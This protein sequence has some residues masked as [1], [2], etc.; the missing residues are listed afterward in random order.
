MVVR[1]HKYY[2]RTYIEHFAT[3]IKKIRYH[4]LFFSGAYSSFSPR[5]VFSPVKI[6]FLRTHRLHLCPDRQNSTPY[7]KFG[8]PHTEF[9]CPLIDLLCA[10]IKFHPARIERRCVHTKSQGSCRMTNFTAI[11]AITPLISATP[12]A[13]PASSYRYSPSA[14]APL[15]S[16]H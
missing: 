3:Y 7:I 12:H 6:E 16:A 11:M 9:L 2:S 14:A 5:D 13:R 8:C 4:I 15:G 10:Y 1:L